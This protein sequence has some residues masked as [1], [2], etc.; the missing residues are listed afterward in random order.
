MKHIEELLSYFQSLDVRFWVDDGK[1]HYSAPE[2]TLTPVLKTQLQEHKS[3]IIEFLKSTDLALNSNTPCILPASRNANLPLSFTQQGLW[4]LQQLEL[5][6]P[7]YNE[8]LAIRLTGILDFVAMEQSLNEIV[9]RHEILRTTFKLVDGQPVQIIAP[10]LTLT[11]PVIDLCQ[12]SEADQKEKVK[13]LATEDIQGFFDLA[14]GPLMRCTLL[15]LRDQ[16]HI[17]LFTIHHII[18]DGW[19]GGVIIRELSTLY[20][21]LSA[22]KSVLLPELPIQYADFAVW[23]RQQLQ[24][25]NIKLQLSYWKQQLENSPPLLQ[26]PTDRPRPPIQTYR[27]ARQSF[28]L[29]KSLTKVLKA[30]SQKAGSTLFMTLLSAFKVLLYRYSGQEDIVVGSAIANR[31][32]VEVEKL[33]GFFVNTLVLRTDVSG[34]PTFEE[35][36]DRVRKVMMGAYANQDLPFERLVE[37]LQPERDADRNPLYQVSFDFQNTPKVGFELPGLTIAPFEIERTRALL[38]LGLDI[39]ETDSKLEC[40]WEYNTDLF[41]W[42]TV[43]RM[44]GHFQTLLEA[45]AT[46]PQQRVSELPLLRESEQYQLLVEWNQTQLDYPKESCIHELFEAQVEQTPNAIA[47]VFEE[48]KLTYAELNR[49]ANQVAHYLKK[50]KVQ[51]EVLVG[52]CVE[53]SLEMVIGLLGILKAGGAYVP[54]DPAYPAER[55]TYM[56]SDSQ[57]SVLLTTRQLR[58]HLPEHPATVIELDTDWGLIAEEDDINPV[59]AGSAETLAYVIYTSGSTGNPKGVLVTHQG[60]CNLAQEPSRFNVQPGSRV[61]QFAS[62]N[63]DASIWEIM[64]ALGSGATLYLGTPISL[65]PGPALMQLLRIQEITHVTLPPTALAAL[66]RE[67]LPALQT[68]IVAGESC[69]AE[70]VAAWSQN[71]QFFNAYGPSESTV[72]A[73]FY[74]CKDVSRVIPIGRP[75]ANTQIYLLDGE[76]QPVPIGVSGELYIGGVGLAR[77]YLNR[78]ELTAQKFISNPFSHSKFK[79]RSSK[80]YRTGDLAKYLPDGNIEFLG[81]ID[82]QVKVRSFRVELGEI[83]AALLQH[84]GVSK[85]VVLVWEDHPGDKRIVAY[86]VLNQNYGFNSDQLQTFLKEKLPNYMIPSAFVVLDAIPLMPNGKVDRDALPVPE[87]RPQ[88]EEAYVMPQTEAERVIA[89]VWQDLLKLEKVGINDNF[90][91]MG[92]HSLLLVRVQTKLNE[93]LDTE[94]PIVELFKYPTIKELAQYLARK[95]DFEK[96]QKLHSKRIHDR[97][98]RQKEA[99]KKQRQR[100]RQQGRKANG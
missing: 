56:L 89:A 43:K 96:I 63:F 98:S 67:E 70:L 87:G 25:E 50:Q 39:T 69:S 40:F 58:Q 99:I 86:L 16:E 45:I 79:V 34:N 61:L 10:N 12:L 80:L 29:P 46:N 55:L 7:F 82:H 52:I 93:V 9:R 54:L 78:P 100:L 32:Q 68:I 5:N 53:R 26:L 85:A 47:L 51:P 27:G 60:L 95:G 1:L 41:E 77:G 84:P 13:R 73:T 18:F 90:F 57:V 49:R 17:L 94:I 14:Q 2:G 15:Q 20:Q 88:L 24:G 31:N 72:C 74:E 48:Q 36:L 3:A 71:R 65:L 42:S 21:A 92:G 23:Q 66:P 44:A 30:L 33:V 91:S 59:A 37:E 83:E 62:L 64:M 76:G 28:V 11:L 35:L 38:D 22:G 97:A 4:F 6:N 8:N 81:R 19:S 75:I